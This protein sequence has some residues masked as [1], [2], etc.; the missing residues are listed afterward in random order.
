ME[1]HSNNEYVL[2]NSWLVTFN[3]SFLNLLII[4]IYLELVQF[5]NFW[6]SARTEMARWPSS[7]VVYLRKLLLFQ[8]ATK[9][10]TTD[11][12]R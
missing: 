10:M 1:Q 6:N 3:I 4:Q 12:N 5:V 9:T 2:F 7:L 8:R 11:S